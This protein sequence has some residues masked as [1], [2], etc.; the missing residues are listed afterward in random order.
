MDNDVWSF[1]DNEEGQLGLGDN[2]SKNKPTNINDIKAKSIS[3]GGQHTILI[4]GIS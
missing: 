2:I 3:C 1:G 4:T